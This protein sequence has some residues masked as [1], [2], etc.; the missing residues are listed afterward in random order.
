MRGVSAVFTSLVVVLSVGGA[1]PVA[2][3]HASTAPAVEPAVREITIPA[4][5][6]LQVRLNS[7]VSSVASR[8]EQPVDATLL[9]PV[10]VGGVTVLPAGSHVTGYVSSVRRSGKV[11]GL[12]HVAVAFRSVSVDGASYPIAAGVARTAPA[13]KKHDAAKIGIQAAGGAV[14]G[15]LVGG[16]KGAA[17]GA[18][19]G[20]GAGTA[21]VLTTRGKEVS[22]PRGSRLSLRLQRAVTVRVRDTRN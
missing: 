18:A 22:L 19:V 16:K 1:A 21:V 5:T 20:G 3:E 15:G 2:V 10:R 13:T 9:V 6:R 12:A 7:S 17:T 11:K 8:L 4:G 14:I